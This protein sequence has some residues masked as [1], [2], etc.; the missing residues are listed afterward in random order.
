MNFVKFYSS[1]SWRISEHEILPVG[2]FSFR[3]V[4]WSHSTFCHTFEGL[5]RIRH[6]QQVPICRWTLAQT[7]STSSIKAVGSQ[8]IVGVAC[9][10]SLLAPGVQP[11][12]SIEEKLA[13]GSLG[14]PFD[15][16]SRHHATFQIFFPQ[17]A[18]ENR[19]CWS[20]VFC[21]LLQSFLILK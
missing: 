14:Y 3:R 13:A 18:F 21:L 5:P 15:L 20:G 19:G 4:L 16:L 8:Q 1:F 10:H 6:A 17:E 12:A 11:R 9:F 7:H 2:M